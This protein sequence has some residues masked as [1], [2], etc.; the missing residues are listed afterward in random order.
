MA[1]GLQHQGDLL[2]TD[3]DA[4]RQAA[5]DSMQASAD[6][7]CRAYTMQWWQQ[8]AS[9]NYSVADSLKLFPRLVEICRLGTDS[10]HPLGATGIPPGASYPFRSF[11]ELI[12][13]YNDSTGIPNDAACNAFLIDAPGPYNKPVALVDMPTYSRIAALAIR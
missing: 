3:L 2:G 1:Q 9:C 11:D 6:R 12:T 10:T 13:H 8:L 7:N 5:A 4:A